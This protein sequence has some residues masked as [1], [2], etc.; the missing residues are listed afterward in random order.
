MHKMRIIRV[1]GCVRPHRH[2]SANSMSRPYWHVCERGGGSATRRATGHFR[3]D[4]RAPYGADE[5][6]RG[7]EAQGQQQSNK[8]TIGTARTT[9]GCCQPPPANQH[10]TETTLL[11][12]A[13][14]PRRSE[15]GAARPRRV[16]TPLHLGARWAPLRNRDNSRRG[17]VTAPPHFKNPPFDHHQ[18]THT[19]HDDVGDGFRL[20]H[21]MR[22]MGVRHGRRSHRSQEKPALLLH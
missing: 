9:T 14:A 17:Q 12:A 1:R 5:Q 20:L 10:G 11:A 8:K 19:H 22:R 15:S 18:R 2:R 3:D 21:P 7:T 16:E 6:T 13:E 4:G